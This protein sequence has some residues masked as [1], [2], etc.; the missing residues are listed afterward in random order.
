MKFFAAP[1]D[2]PNVVAPSEQVTGAT[3]KCTVRIETGGSVKTAALMRVKEELA[4]VKMRG[5]DQERK[6][7]EKGERKAK[8]GG[9]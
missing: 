1:D 8:G 9:R 6:T 5:T 2:D 4:V 3:K 7:D